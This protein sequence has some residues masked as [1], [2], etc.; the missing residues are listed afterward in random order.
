[1]TQQAGDEVD[2][3]AF[4]TDVS[5]WYKNTDWGF[6]TKI[7][8]YSYISIKPYFAGTTCLEMGPADGEMTRFIMADFAHLS[9]VDGSPTFAAAA[10]ALGDNVTGHASLF[11]EFEPT[12]RYDTI[13]MS[14]VL[15]HV[16]DPVGILVRAASWLRPNGRI[17]AVVPNAD[18][19]HR[20]LGV[21][22]GMLAHR[23][24]LN[25]QDIRIG[26][27]RVY[28]REELDVDIERAGLRSVA[29][30]GIFLKLLSNNQ[31][32]VFDD[33]KLVDGM[34]ELGKDMPELCSEIFAVCI[35]D[36]GH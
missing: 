7:V 12:D 1:M 16:Q 30:G 9:V 20:R 35:P 25:D 4:L 13:V 14:H 36:R 27:R 22:L 21:K 24:Q 5:G 26:H 29:K 11:E 2:E 34:F 6:Y 28:N 33:D 15:E 31:M 10:E 3:Q 17:I 32:L 8:W 19:L 18:S 23:G